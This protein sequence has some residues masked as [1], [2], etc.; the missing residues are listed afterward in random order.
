MPPHVLQGG[1]TTVG[2]TIPI[3]VPITV[4]ASAPVTATDSASIATPGTDTTKS[5]NRD[6]K[7]RIENCSDVEDL[8]NDE[9]CLNNRVL[10]TSVFRKSSNI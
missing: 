4:T 6:C 3:P 10:T 2:V 7:D 9:V 8:C 1:E 5:G